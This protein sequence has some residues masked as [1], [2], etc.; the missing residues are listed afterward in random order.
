[1]KLNLLQLRVAPRIS[2]LLITLSKRRPLRIN[3]QKDLVAPRAAAKIVPAPIV[4]MSMAK[5][6]KYY[7]SYTYTHDTGLSA[8]V[9]RQA[10][11]DCFIITSSEHFEVTFLVNQR[12]V[13]TLCSYLCLMFTLTTHRVGMFT[14]PC[15]SLLSTH[16]I[17]LFPSSFPS[18]I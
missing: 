14:L 3:D 4:S 5:T 6:S 17:S 12:A 9:D 7:E 13:F 1:M 8:I 18:S 11:C 10:H 15:K 16:F 2:I